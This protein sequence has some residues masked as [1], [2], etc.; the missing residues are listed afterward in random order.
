MHKSKDKAGACFFVSFSKNCIKSTGMNKILLLL[1]CFFLLAGISAAEAP[2][3]PSEVLDL[4]AVL[5]VQESGRVKPLDTVARFSLLRLNG[6]R[7]LTLDA[8]TGKR[9]LSALE[10]FLDC[11]FQPEA[12]DDYRCFSV[13]SY[14]AVVALGIE[15]HGKKRDRYS[16]NELRPGLDRLMTLARQASEIPRETQTFIDTQLITL[17]NNVLAYESLTQFLDFARASYETSGNA[18]LAELFESEEPARTSG[19]LKQ[20]PGHLETVVQKSQTLTDKE[21][22]PLAQG[23]NALFTQLDTLTT[24]ARLFAL[25]PPEK[26]EEIPWLSPADIM[27]GAFDSGT[28]MEIPIGFVQAFETLVNT[29]PAS[30]LFL[31]TLK[32]LH[33]AVTSQAAARGEYRHVP[34]EVHYYRGRYL[35][36]GQWLFVLA[37]IFTALSWLRKEAGRLSLL[38]NFSLL[39]PILLLGFGIAL[40]CI[41]RERPPVT[42]L[43]ETILFT[44]LIGAS[45]GFLLEFLVRNRIPMSLGA[46][47][48][49]LGMFFAWR[50]EAREGTDTMPAVI[51]VLDTNFWLATHV[52]TIIVGYGAGLF[53]SALG[54]V[55]VFF[56][57][58]PF[59]KHASPFFANLGRVTYGVFSFCLV[60]T[61]IGTVLGGIWAAQSW[62]RFWGWDPKEN[63]ALLI[64]LWALAVLHARRGSY[65]RHDGIALSAIVLGMIVVF[66]WWGVNAL[67]VGL[68]SYGFTRGIWGALSLFWALEAAVITAGGTAMWLRRSRTDSA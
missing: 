41:I 19:I 37:F 66:A 60:F 48:G 65:L 24:T 35:F 45:L 20:V 40:R 67:G 18:L 68:H 16:Y 7:T 1:A 33:T 28:S 54:H 42:T 12:A 4:F 44:A 2:R 14:E 51:A 49:A 30:P 10:W 26:G 63:G 21:R 50:Y 11:L 13:E 6:K 8:A 62:G 53:A 31:D 23:M 56:R 55:H 57:I 39:P 34:L 3:W 46:L 58:F 61:L 17:A 15:P 64:I 52:T 27:E 5:P 43:Y 29:P 38:A 25:F 59:K 22:E 9:S 32:R 47:F 36:F